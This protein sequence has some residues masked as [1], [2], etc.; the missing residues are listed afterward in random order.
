MI[1]QPL[2]P[3]LGAEQALRAL[4]EAPELIC[5][6]SGKGGWTYVAA[7]DEGLFLRS[8]AD[9]PQA[10][11]RGGVAATG[12]PAA[13][14]GGWLLQV[15]Y[16]LPVGQHAAAVAHGPHC[17][18][19]VPLR[20][21]LAWDGDG[22]AWA[23]GTESQAVADLR[24]RACGPAL[25]LP[26]A[27]L[28]PVPQP[29]WP[30]AEHRAKVQALRQ[31]IAAGEC[32]QANLAV[33]FTAPFVHAQGDLALFL[34]LRSRSPAPY[35][36]FWRQPAGPGLAARSI[37]SHSPECFLQGDGINLRSEPIKGTR[38]R[39]LGHEEAVVAELQSSAKDRAELAMIV[40]LV[41]NDLGRIA[42]VG[43][44]RVA[45]PAM[46]IDL[47][48]VHHAAA[49][50]T[51][52]PRAQSQVSDWLAAAYPAGSI[53][54]APKIQVMGLLQ[55]IEGGDR[56]PYCGSFGWLGERSC[57][58][59]VAIRTMVITSDQIRFHAGGGIVA[60]SDPEAE[61]QEV[62]AKASAMTA[63]LVAGA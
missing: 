10:S 60:D 51:C 1:R 36:A 55:E 8:L 47:D 40:D 29:Q 15:D 26:V 35:A 56:G 22:R 11:G 24:A 63:A 39:Q 23:C 46:R 21:W 4:A 12:W 38:R 53:T 16:G 61:W 9:L 37:C 7:P 49:R 58:L 52:R 42:E 3:G 2:P 28:A 33:P 14:D 25:P 32:F 43:S 57:A 27:P 41:R 31:R 20:A 30:A 62:L 18:R 50:I 6:D 19:A 44:V 13:I 59:A 34:R 17:G 48:Y 5:L 54:G 45:D